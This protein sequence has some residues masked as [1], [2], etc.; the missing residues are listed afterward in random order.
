M[1]ST[2]DVVLATAIRTQPIPARCWFRRTQ[3]ISL[4]LLA[5][6]LVLTHPRTCQHNELTLRSIRWRGRLR[7]DL[8]D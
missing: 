7:R 1:S 5:G 6:S 8:P 2:G 4:A 3:A